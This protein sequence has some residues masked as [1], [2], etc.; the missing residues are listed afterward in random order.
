MRSR[1]SWSWSRPTCHIYAYN[2]ELTRQTAASSATTEAESSR[3][4]LRASSVV[5]GSEF[6]SSAS[7]AARSVRAV[8]AAPPGKSL[9]GYTGYY[10]R[11]LAMMNEVD[12]AKSSSA[13]ASSASAA[14]KSSTVS[15]SSSSA[16]TKSVSMAA[17]KMT[18]VQQKTTTSVSTKAAV[19]K[20]SATSG[21]ELLTAH[22]KSLEYGR[23]SASKILRR[24]E[25]H[26]VNSGKDPRHVFVP[27]I[28]TNTDDICKVVADLH[29]APFEGKEITSAKAAST[30]GRLKIERME[31]ELD[32]VTSSAMAYKSIY[33]K[34]ASQMAAEA[35][36]ACEAEASSSK[37]TRKTIVESSSTKRVAA[38]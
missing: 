22:N 12:S 16:A 28:H 5:G 35:M 18:S 33:L 24:A 25:I 26:A 29:I 31:K 19:E 37:K 1:S 7:A 38:A 30:Q 4:S 3:R 34:S 21:A 9:M 17:S 23:S 6:A 27:R 36:S 8:S 14:A 20:T 2:R 32:K 11:Q 10:G 13:S 15:A